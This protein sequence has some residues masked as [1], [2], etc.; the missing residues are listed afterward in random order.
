[1]ARSLTVIMTVTAAA[2]PQ[3]GPAAESAAVRQSRQ[4]ALAQLAALA[5]ES[6]QSYCRIT[7]VPG[8]RR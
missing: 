7:A 2:R 4:L 1:M 5:A 8:F 6:L 3:P